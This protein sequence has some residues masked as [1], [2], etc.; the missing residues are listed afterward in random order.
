MKV[1]KWNYN[2]HDYDEYVLPSGAMT[3]IDDLERTIACAACG[4]PVIAGDTYT[5]KEIH[6]NA[7]FG[8]RTAIEY[9]PADSE[10]VNLANMRHVFLI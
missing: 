7:G 2:K 5:S 1:G 4:K 9:Y 10:V 8:E 3:Y 6:T